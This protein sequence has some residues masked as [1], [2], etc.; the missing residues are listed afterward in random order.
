MFVTTSGRGGAPKALGTATY[1]GTIIH[2]DRV[3]PHVMLMLALF[4]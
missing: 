2:N 3:F 4:P 1:H